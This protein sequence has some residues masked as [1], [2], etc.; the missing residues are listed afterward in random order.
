MSAPSLQTSVA[1]G[2][3]RLGPVSKRPHGSDEAIHATLAPPIQQP[4]WQK[5]HGCRCGGRWGSSWYQLDFWLSQCLE[6]AV[7]ECL[8]AQAFA[9]SRSTLP[10][11]APSGNGGSARWVQAGAINDNARQIA[12][13]PHD[14]VARQV[15]ARRLTTLQVTVALDG[16]VD[17][18]VM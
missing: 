4:K 14:C 7:A 16:C 8:S 2:A 18:R 11:R 12:V 17:S 1:H 10:D 13:P 9:W 15:R 5:D 3:R 6:G